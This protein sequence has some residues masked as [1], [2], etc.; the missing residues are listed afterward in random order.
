[1]AVT[2]ANIVVGAATL[3]IAGVDVGGLQGGV[4]FKK[5]TTFVDID[6][7]Q[8]AGIAAKIASFEIASI[9]TTMLEA[10]IT[11]MRRAMNEAASQASGSHLTIGSA[12]PATQEYALTVVA[13]APNSGTRT[14]TFHRAIMSADFEH[15]IGSRE[16]A[17][18]IPVTFELLKDP[19]NNN[20]FCTFVD[21]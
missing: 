13:K 10:T 1:M 19:S 20:N 7:D 11:N 17:S 6:A 2:T 15:M 9:S 16:S 12:A 5:T 3:S 8:L 21:T 14:W 4:T 18:V